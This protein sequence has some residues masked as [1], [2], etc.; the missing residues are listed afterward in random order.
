MTQFNQHSQ[1]THIGSAKKGD[2]Y[3]VKVY[4]FNMINQLTLL[5]YNYDTHSNVITLL[6]LGMHEGFYKDLKLSI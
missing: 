4:K 5:A 2:L 1:K 3:G 6:A